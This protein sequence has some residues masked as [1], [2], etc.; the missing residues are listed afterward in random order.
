MALQKIY[1]DDTSGH[2]VLKDFNLVAA[3]G[4]GCITLAGLMLDMPLGDILKK[5]FLD[6]SQ[7]RQLL[8]PP[9]GI[10]NKLFG[11]GARYSTKK[12]R[13]ALKTL[14]GD[15]AERKL[16]SVFDGQ[17]SAPRP[18]PQILICAYDCDRNRA[19]FF[20]SDRASRCASA[21]ADDPKLVDAI[22][23]ATTAP[24]PLFDRPAEGTDGRFWDGAAAGLY[25]PVLAAVTEARAN[26]FGAD[27]IRVLSLGTGTIQL[28]VSNAGGNKKLVRDRDSIALNASDLL[29]TILYDPADTLTFVTHVMLDQLFPG[30]TEE[31]PVS[32]TVIR[33]SPV[34][35]PLP[36]GDKWV[37]PEGLSDDEVEKLAST[38][39][40]AIEPKGVELIRLL[41]ERWVEGKVLNQPIRAGREFGYEIGKER[42]PQAV[43]AWKAI[44]N[45]APGGPPAGP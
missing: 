44:R 37:S 27:V 43:E 38:G 23:A 28:P 20:R 31:I 17:K 26:R 14:L 34:V 18:R 29:R 1:T 39:L 8:A 24:Y 19:E 41:G 40:D 21:T 3:N 7:R 5:W 15:M 6:E 12:K 36:Q 45:P 32:G 35:R 13:A 2:Q 30:D 16:A 42:F 25:N 9:S 22:N 33:L 11:N 10:W 4:A